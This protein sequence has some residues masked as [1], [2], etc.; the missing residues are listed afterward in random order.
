MT[1]SWIRSCLMMMLFT[2]VGCAS[3][4]LTT[5]G[6][7]SSA[8]KLPVERPYLLGGKLDSGNLYPNTVLI[9]TRLN[10][11]DEGICSGVL[12]SPHRVLTAAHCVCMEKPVA[13]P[14]G[15]AR[16]I[17]DGST[18]MQAPTVTPIIY[19]R[20]TPP[21][22]YKGSKVEPHPELK[23]LYDDDGALLFAQSD[24]AVIHL[25]KAIPGVQSVRLASAEVGVGSAVVLVGFGFTDITR[26][27][28]PGARYF[29][30]TEIAQVDSEVLRITKPGLNAYEGDSGGPCFKWV[31]GSTNPVLV[32]ITRGGSAP[33]YSTITS[34][35]FPKNRE[36]IEKIQREDTQGD[37]DSP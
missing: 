21:L 2:T 15:Q 11:R 10:D 17:I 36:W 23:L 25:Q 19:G 30:R 33:I 34:T 24:L 14:M 16:T 4:S 9:T 31:R 5:E 29:G 7:P 27:R 26:K 20:S 35:V 22:P 3:H 13:T 32:G 8:D 37:A 28:K 18:C 6:A 1:H 12:I